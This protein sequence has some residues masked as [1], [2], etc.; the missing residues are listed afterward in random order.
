[1][2]REFLKMHGLGNDFVVIDARREPY[3]PSEAEVRAI[4]DRRTGV[5]CDQFIVLNPAVT[6]GVSGFMRIHN[7][8][9]SEV[10]ACGNASRCVGWLLMEEAGAD[11]ARFETNAGVLEATRGPAGTVTVDMGPARLAWNEIPLAGPADTLRL[12]VEH[13]GFAGPVAV[14]MGNPHAVFFVD[15]AEAVPLAEVGPALEHHAAFP[16]RTNVEFATVL[17]PTRIRM[18]VWERGAGI[19]QA[20]GSGACAT[21]VA[22]IRRGL[23]ARKADVVLDGGTLTIEWLENGHVLM[24]GPVAHS[25]TGR[26]SAGLGG[27]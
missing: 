11:R 2:M 25:F 14:S 15:D 18:R 22:A 7:A 8:D 26:L 24:T 13:G 27:T 4:A 6:P 23:T 12:D 3:A 20:C 9:G 1:M 21:A 5:G 17:S 10:S 16:E 19:T